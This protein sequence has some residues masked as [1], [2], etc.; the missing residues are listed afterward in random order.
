MSRGD[1]LRVGRYVIAIHVALGVL[2]AP[3]AAMAAC[4]QP[5]DTVT[6]VAIRPAAP[7]VEYDPIRGLRGLSVE[8]FES[9]AIEIGMSPRVDSMPSTRATHYEFVDCPLGSQLEALGQGDIDLI[10]SP[11]T[12]TAERLE[13]FDFTHQYIASGLTVAHRET[14]GIDLGHAASTIMRTLGHGSAPLV[15]GAFLLMNLALALILARHWR[16]TSYAIEAPNKLSASAHYTL[17][18]ALRTGGFTGVS[19]KFRTLSGRLIEVAAVTVGTS[20]SAVVVGLITTSLVASL[21]SGASFRADDLAGRS[22]ATIGNSTAQRFVER[23]E[24]GRSCGPAGG[25]LA[26]EEHGGAADCVTV[27]DWHSSMELLAA[28]EIDAVVGD[29][30]QLSYIARSGALNAPIAIGARTFA[31]EPYGWGVAPSRDELRRRIDRA[32]I[33]RLRSPNW[34]G[35]V[36]EYLGQGAIAPG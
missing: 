11:L 18:A 22:I 33:R 34:R 25:A 3:T 1:G 7:F 16:G 28:G 17:E 14:G 21:E 12:I 15:L 27:A 19:D 5:D 4:G 13:R 23:L 8:L 2:A 36:E 26:G 30:V 29:W 6:R 10:I 32:L 20:L 31:N 35:L 24:G 9:I